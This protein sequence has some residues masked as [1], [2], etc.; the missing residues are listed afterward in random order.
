MRRIR[1]RR[2]VPTPGQVRPCSSSSFPP[3]RARI[4]SHRIASRGDVRS[5]HG[6]G[7]GDSPYSV[8]S[9]TF[10][11]T[12][13][14][15][16]SSVRFLDILP[17]TRSSFNRSSNECARSHLMMGR[18]DRHTQILVRSG[19]SRPSHP[20]T[21]PPTLTW[22]RAGMIGARPL[23]RAHTGPTF[24]VKK[25]HNFIFIF[26]FNCSLARCV[27]RQISRRYCLPPPSSSSPRQNGERAYVDLI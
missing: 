26:M 5:I 8:V 6:D 15:P 21:Y 20:S 24:S 9:A 1:L 12:T 4:A 22:M 7:D 3:A 17:S 19:L 23:V 14:H 16:P 13:S 2:G 18:T 25:C 27:T 11:A 10:S